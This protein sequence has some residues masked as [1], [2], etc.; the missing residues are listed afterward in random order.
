MRKDRLRF[1]KFIRNKR[2]HD[3]RELT[4]AEVAETLGISSSLYGHIENNQR[5]PFDI[6]KMEVF[7]EL[8]NFTK[9]DRAKMYDLAAREKSEIPVDLEDM[10]LYE[11]I[12]ETIF[13]LCRKLQNGD[14]DEEEW[15][16]LAREAYKEAQ[17]RK[18]GADE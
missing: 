7:A 2:V 12:G 13:G 9:E 4:Q 11:E 5:P 15:K 14:F 6:E 18:G 10:L 1:G 17:R 8:F 3:S 16:T